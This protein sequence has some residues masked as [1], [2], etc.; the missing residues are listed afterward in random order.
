MTTFRQKPTGYSLAFK[1][2]VLKRI[3]SNEI[4]ANQASKEYGIGGKMTVYRWLDRKEKILGTQL[5]QA[6]TDEPK[7]TKSIDELEAELASVRRLL[8]QERLRSEAYLAMIKLAEQK[9]NLPIEKK[10]GAKR[11][12]R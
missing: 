9:Y 8:E 11:S 3:L 7:G 6:M 1:K 10:S 4:T 2:Q 5:P 12:K